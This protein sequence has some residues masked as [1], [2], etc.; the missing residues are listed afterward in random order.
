MADQ[1]LMS[2]NLVNTDPSSKIKNVISHFKSEKKFPKYGFE[3]PFSR[4]QLA[5]LTGLRIE[6]VIRAVKKLESEQRL[7]ILNRRIYV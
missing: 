4:R 1:Y 3:V 6:T 5:N 7:K 2:T